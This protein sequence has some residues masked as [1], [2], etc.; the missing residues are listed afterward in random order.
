MS[1]EED[2]ISNDNFDQ[3][4]LKSALPVLI[5]FWA[6]WCGPCRMV[7]PVVDEIKKQYEGK[8]KVFKVNT[9]ELPDIASKYGIRSI[10]TLM[11]FNDGKKVDMLVGA[12]PYKILEK[13]VID[14]LA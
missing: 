13:A 9:D 7:G 2:E 4:V 5:D 10:P 8:I 3:K 14:Q 11:I 1:K 12:L 6:P